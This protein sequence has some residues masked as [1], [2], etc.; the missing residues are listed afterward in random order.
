MGP[1]HTARN[2]FRLLTII[3]LAL[4]QFGCTS[5]REASRAFAEG[6]SVSGARVVADGA[7][8]ELLRAQ[9]FPQLGAAQG[10]GMH[11]GMIYIY[12]DANTG[13]VVEFRLVEPQSSE[14]PMLEPTGRIIR[15]TRRGENILPHPTGLAWHPLHGCFIG[16][17]VRQKGVIWHIDWPRA[18]ADGTLDYAVLNTT[19][20]DLAVNGTRPEFVK[21]RDGRWMIA[22]SDYGAEGNEIR[23]YDP[24]RL[25]HASR[26]S[27]AGVI[28]QRSRSGPFVQTLAWIDELGLVVKVQNQTPGL[29]YRLTFF[30][31][32]QEIV[33]DPGLPRGQRPEHADDLGRFEPFDF[34]PPDDELEGFV[35]L[36][37]I[38]EHGTAL[39]LLVSAFRHDNVWIARLRVPTW[40]ASH[41]R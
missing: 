27:A 5:P 39:A 28:R 16:D 35:L 7:S 1:Q 13:V 31:L 18:L 6:S 2:T 38:D 34:S 3:A 40:A 10:V 30:E 12:G 29:G 11:D 8:I 20:D 9:T 36:T 41:A 24:E 23:L 21:L 37:P 14:P 26:T 15:L 25:A 22:T 4:V 32:P 19:I 33:N 17:T